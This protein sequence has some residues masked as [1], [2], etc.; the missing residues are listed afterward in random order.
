MR[1]TPKLVKL[2]GI[3]LLISFVTLL[4]AFIVA[5]AHQPR[6]SSQGVSREQYAIC[7]ECLGW[8]D[9]A[10]YLSVTPRIILTDWLL[11]GGAVGSL[12]NGLRLCWIKR[13]KADLKASQLWLLAFVY[14]LGF[15][16]LGLSFLIPMAVLAC[17]WW[18][19]LDEPSVLTSSNHT[20]T[21]A[22]VSNSE[23]P[24]PLLS[25]SELTTAQQPLETTAGPATEV[26]VQSQSL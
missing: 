3:L 1:D 24:Q 7:L 23:L 25:N 9:T 22:T 5:M 6:C 2:H 19:K 21:T 10:L 16:A 12:M 17:K 8:A 20:T 15:A 18:R 14:A 4:A 26:T 13:L 11:L